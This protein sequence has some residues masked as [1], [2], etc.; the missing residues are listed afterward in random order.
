VLEV[1]RIDGTD[2]IVRAT[3]KSARIPT[4]VGAAWR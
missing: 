3:T 1:E 2:L 4:Y